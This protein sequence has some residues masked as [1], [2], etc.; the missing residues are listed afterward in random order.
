MQD[1]IVDPR[2]VFEDEIEM[3]LAVRLPDRTL[4][5]VGTK[6]SKLAFLDELG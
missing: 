1:L 4:H 2:F 5:V 6:A 3:R